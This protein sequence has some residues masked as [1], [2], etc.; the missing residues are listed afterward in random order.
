MTPDTHHQL[1]ELALRK[2]RLQLRAAAQRD[3]LIH[4]AAALDPLLRGADRIGDGLRWARSHPALLAGVAA[5]LLVARPRRTVR[6]L[7]RG[8]FGWQLLQRARA[9]VS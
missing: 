4:H 6:W 9:L 5:F 3:A 2:Q 1:V 8:W 7:R